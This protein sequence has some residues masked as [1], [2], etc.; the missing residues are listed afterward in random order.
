MTKEILPIINTMHN[1]TDTKNRSDRHG[2]SEEHS[3]VL[4]LTLF[5]L[6]GMYAYERKDSHTYKVVTCR[7]H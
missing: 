5:E 6:L 3:E 2:K 4:P 7:G 1:E